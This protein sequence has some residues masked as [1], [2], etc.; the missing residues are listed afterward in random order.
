MERMLEFKLARSMERP[1]RSGI[2]G[3]SILFSR[4]T[5]LKLLKSKLGWRSDS[6]PSVDG[7][8]ASNNVE[9]S[10][11]W[12]CGTAETFGLLDKYA[13]FGRA[14]SAYWQLILRDEQL[15]QT[16][17]VASH[18]IFDRVHG[19]QHRLRDLGISTGFDLQ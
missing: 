5:V 6:T 16:G 3:T 18:R 13:R 10:S 14:C 2:T 7:S 11:M 17:K 4:L 8:M 19:S 12:V 1:D 9:S 15:E